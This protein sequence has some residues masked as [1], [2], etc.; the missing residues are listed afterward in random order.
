VLGEAMET[1][2]REIFTAYYTYDQFSKRSLS[3]VG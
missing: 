3:S 2:L 1:K